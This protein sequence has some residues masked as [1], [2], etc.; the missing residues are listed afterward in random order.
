MKA[1]AKK[2]FI[3]V[4][5]TIFAI[6]FILTAYSTI[7]AASVNIAYEQEEIKV[8]VGNLDDTNLLNKQSFLNDRKAIIDKFEKENPGETSKVLI[9]FNRFL[10]ADEVEKLLS[11]NENKVIIDEIFISIPN[12]TGRA[13][14]VSSGMGNIGDEIERELNIMIDNENN[15]EIKAEHKRMKAEYGIFAI[16]CET[17]NITISE[18]SKNEAVKFSDIFYYPK[19][20]RKSNDTGKNIS[21]I[22]LP[23]KPDGT[24]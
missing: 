6:M 16:S 12:E 4:L 21:Y 10:T 15:A 11:R 20:E 14:I 2:T 9:T 3:L 8:F 1:K 24:Y 18:I 22:A 19:A 17:D 5:S 23:Q 13:I 7:S